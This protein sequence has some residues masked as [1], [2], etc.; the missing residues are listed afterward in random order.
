MNN[1]KRKI[2]TLELLPLALTTIIAL[3]ACFST[4]Y[5]YQT[6]KIASGQENRERRKEII[7]WVTLL[8]GIAET[9]NK[10]EQESASKSEADT[11]SN[12][13]SQSDR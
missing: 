1:D 13:A 2:F 11:S 7:E 3:S 8:K 9:V 12:K 6:A 5:T 10:L 4:Y